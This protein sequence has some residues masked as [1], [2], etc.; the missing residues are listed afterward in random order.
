MAVRKMCLLVLFYSITPSSK[1]DPIQCSLK[2]TFIIYQRRPHQQFYAEISKLETLKFDP[3][4][5][6]FRSFSIRKITTQLIY[7][8]LLMHNSIR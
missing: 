2:C 8:F 7:R 1:G 5:Q 6:I 4:C 3:K